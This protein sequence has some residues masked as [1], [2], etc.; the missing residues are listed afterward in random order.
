MRIHQA[1]LDTLFQ[2]SPSQASH[3]VQHQG[4]SLSDALAAVGTQGPLNS[5]S[6][7]RDFSPLWL[8]IHQPKQIRC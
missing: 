2:L 1:F 6:R 4:L 5:C 7:M 8:L 3:L